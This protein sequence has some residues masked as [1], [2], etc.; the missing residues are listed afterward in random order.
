MKA[1]SGIF[2]KPYDLRIEEVNSS[3]KAK[4]GPGKSKSVRYSVPM[5]NAL[6]ASQQRED[7][8]SLP[9]RPAMS[10]AEKS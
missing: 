7:T 6:K 5:L 8:I 4:S 1:K 2:A 9:I 3:I 10:G